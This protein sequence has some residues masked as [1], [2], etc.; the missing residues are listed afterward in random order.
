MAGSGFHP[1][2]IALSQVTIAS[3]NSTAAESTGTPVRSAPTVD[4]I[5]TSV[6]PRGISSSGRTA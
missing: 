3:W 2:A 6:F 1:Q 5:R 4:E